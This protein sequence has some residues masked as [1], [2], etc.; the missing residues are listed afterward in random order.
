M[1]QNSGKTYSI[2]D[3]EKMTGVSQ[4][5]LRAWEGKHI[6]FPERIVCGD[7]AYRRYSQSEIRL[8]SKVKFYRDEG[9]TCVRSTI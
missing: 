8:F 1:Y 2:G 3:A 4:R 7:R 6:P 5:V 9:Y